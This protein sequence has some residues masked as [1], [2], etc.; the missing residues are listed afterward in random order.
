MSDARIQRER[1]DHLGGELARFGESPSEGGIAILVKTTTDT[2]YPTTAG[3]F[4]CCNPVEADGDEAEGDAATFAAD[5]SRKLYAYN[6][7][8][9][10]PP[11]GTITVAVAQSGLWFFT[12][13]IKP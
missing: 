10:I 13:C 2:T 5:T 1:Y 6:L 8:S 12:Y 9:E 7:G 11:A 3:A 4:Y